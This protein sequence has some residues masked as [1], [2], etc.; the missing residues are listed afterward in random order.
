MHALTLGVKQLK[1]SQ[2]R[3][4]SGDFSFSSYVKAVTKSAYYH[5]KNLARI[6]CFVSSQD[7]EKLV[8]GFGGL[9]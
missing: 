7:L 1:S 3:S 9:L 4:D 2:K 6:R 5:L 8:D